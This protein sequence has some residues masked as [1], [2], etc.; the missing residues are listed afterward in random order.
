MMES[1]QLKALE[2]VTTSRIIQSGDT[3][4]VPSQ[5]SGTKYSV[6]LSPFSCSC[7]DFEKRQQ[8]CKHLLAVLELIQ[9]NATGQEIPTPE[10][11][12]KQTYKQEWTAYNQAQTN[13]KARFLELLYELCKLVIDIPRKEGAGR[14][15]L[16]LGDMIFC[17]VYKIYS[18]V[19]GRR[20]MTDLKEAQRRGYI[21]KTP[22]FNSIFNYL[23]LVLRQPSFDD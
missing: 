10:P 4:I 6:R 17:A 13:E 1:R 9:H 23:E 20:S 14:T 3:W 5:S 8:A 12:K 2:I 18:T 7:P 21:S 19:S 11:V 16:P 22:H 15:R